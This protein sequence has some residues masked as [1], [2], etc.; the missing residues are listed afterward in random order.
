MILKNDR[1]L[2]ISVGASRKDTSWKPQLITIGELW[3][4]LKTPVRGVETITQYLALKKS[5][6]DDLKDVGGFVAGAL[7]GGRRKADAVTGRDIVTL[8]FDTIPA[9][10]TDGIIQS[11]EN[12]GCGYCIYSTRKHM[13]TAPRL[14][15]L[16]PL[17]RTVTADEYEP[18]ARH[19][20]AQIGIQMADPTTFQASRLMYWPSCS[21]D[22]EYIFRYKDAP[23]IM[24]DL[25]LDAY[26]DWHDF[27]SWPQVPGAVSYQKLAMKQ[28]DPDTKP[29]IVGTFNRAYGDVFNAMDKLLPGIY[30]PVDTDPN[31]FTYLG[32]S[33]T[34]GAV[35]YDH[36]KFLF[37]HH[38]TDPCSGKLVNAFDLVRLHKFGDRDDTA[39]PNT[40]NN[41]LPSYTA[42]CE[43]AVADPVVSAF[44]AKERHEQAMQDFSRITQSSNNTTAD[45]DSYDWMQKLQLNPK[46]GTVKS[47]I[48]NIIIILDN[49]PLLKGKFALNQF[50]GRGEVL[51]KLPWSMDGERRLWSDTDSNGLYWY[52]E[53][54]Y[55]ITGRGSIDA[56]LDIHAATHAFNEVQDYI[57]K[58]VWDGIPRLDT[59]FIDYLGAE[60]DPVGY[61]RAVCR[62]AF[63]A[64]VAR[65]MDPGCKYDCM[66]ILCGA[67]GLGKSTILD[68][69]SRGWF[70]DSIRTFEGKEAS[71]LLQGVWLVEVAELDAFRRT[72]VARIKQFLSLRADRYRAAYGRNVKEL[73]RC[74]VFFGTC[75]QMDFLQ[76]TTGNRRF[77]PVDVGEQPHTKNV[78]QNLTPDTVD[79]IWAEAKMRWMMG[80]Q[81]YLTGEVEKEAQ[82]RQESHREAS[83][84]EGLIHEFVERQVPDDWS[85]WPLDRRRDFW[86]NNATGDYN[87][88]SR[89]RICALEVWCELFFGNQKD[90]KPQDVREINAILAN[91]PHWKR[92]KSS[93]R[94]GPYSVQR[95]FIPG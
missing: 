36:G 16:I 75:N 48:D 86:A 38:A 26:D 79:Q 93:M 91:I 68:K 72:D 14:R 56:A 83:P 77:W 76:D 21:A 85:K 41:R 29:G 17:D 35:I 34:G 45:S 84:R 94:C 23:L 67:Q 59:L 60:D 78:W 90:M 6:Q 65:A 61:T 73:P 81:L 62:K 55:D 39:A 25:V 4:R 88:V 8:D 7:N 49:D 30:E 31:R 12:M 71:E 87:L 57:K 43:F 82:N 46:A 37:S 18:I 63:T 54:A 24:A 95:G 40:P 50:A 58:L 22:G 3:D 47:T 32:G 10:G 2:T 52:L 69:M 9:Y 19:I 15:I 5:Q 11:V 20:A 28:G 64:A 70:N 1:Q 42:M 53:K 80:E 89:D 44:M 51:G 33:T 66:L 13:Q 27:S 92:S 74:C